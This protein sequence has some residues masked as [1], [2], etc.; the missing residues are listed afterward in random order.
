MKLIVCVITLMC[1]A[2]CKGLQALPISASS[3]AEVNNTFVIGGGFPLPEFLD[4]RLTGSFFGTPA[5]SLLAAPDT[6]YFSDY[7]FVNGLG[8][9]NPDTYYRINSA[10]R[11]VG[12]EGAVASNNSEYYTA[13]IAGEST[14]V[15]VQSEASAQVALQ[16]ELYETSAQS[17]IFNGTFLSL[18]NLGAS[19]ITFL[20]EGI[21][22]LDIFSVANGANALAQNNVILA[23][24]FESSHELNVQFGDLDPYV[25]SE[26]YSGQNASVSIQRETDVMGGGEIS[27]TGSSQA[28]NNSAGSSDAFGSAR[29]RYVLGITMQASETISMRQSVRYA[30]FAE[31]SDPTQVNSPSVT[32]LLPLFILAFLITDFRYR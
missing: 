16:S 25:F 10:T 14:E 15:G 7:E 4:S 1:V 5:N 27:L 23:M 3:G 26:N 28:F 22:E 32:A 30:N 20:I 17:D 9:D 31:I 6:D 18:T 29:M 19:S 11:N 24:L 12:T 8:I 13:R 2:W 21:F